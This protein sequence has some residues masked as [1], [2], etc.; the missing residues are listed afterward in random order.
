[1]LTRGI[2]IG[3]KA[4]VEKVRSITTKIVHVTS[5]NKI[6]EN[7]LADERGFRTENHGRQKFFL[8]NR[9]ITP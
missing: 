2:R 4:F 6:Y 9:G 8:S 1:M 5:A 7:S 3:V